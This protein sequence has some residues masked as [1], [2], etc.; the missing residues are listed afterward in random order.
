MLPSHSK[1]WDVALELREI[2]R[3]PHIARDVTLL[4][5]SK[6]YHVAL[7]FVTNLNGAG[8]K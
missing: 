1:G 3:C 7:S 4:S 8:L 5:H 6:G 2:G